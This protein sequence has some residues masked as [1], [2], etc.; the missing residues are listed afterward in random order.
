MIQLQVKDTGDVLGEISEEDLQ[1][2]IDNL[3]EESSDDT[4]YYIDRTTVELFQEAGA[5]DK[6]IYL[7]EQALG[8]NDDAEIAWSRV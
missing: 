1:F 7:L 6:L 8:D 3:E 2:L 4:D 5:S